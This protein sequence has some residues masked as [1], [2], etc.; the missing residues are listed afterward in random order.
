MLEQ[1]IRQA[2]FIPADPVIVISSSGT[3]NWKKDKC[4]SELTKT[5]PYKLQATEISMLRAYNS[6]INTM[7]K[8][9]TQHNKDII[10]RWGKNGNGIRE[11]MTT[12][13]A[14]GIQAFD[15]TGYKL[16]IL[17]ET[18]LKVKKILISYLSLS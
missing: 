13:F 2:T 16:F 6:T 18:I 17:I 12:Y 15:H 3:P 10:A 11:L 5:P 14:S 4:G 7:E 9:V 8:I 1:F